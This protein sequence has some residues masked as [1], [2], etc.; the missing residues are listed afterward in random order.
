MIPGTAARLPDHTADNVN[1]RIRAA[2]DARVLDAARR[3]E[4]MNGRLDDI[5]RRLADLEQEW[6]IE[7]TL[8]TNAAALALTGT[9]LGAFVDRRFLALPALVTGFLLQHAIQGWCPPLPI[10]R[11]RGVRT[12]REITEE[13][14]ALKAL[15]GDFDNLPG[16]PATGGEARGRA[17]IVAARQR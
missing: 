17:A 16:D 8:E 2:S 9:V 12:Q 1:A 15:R 6:D 5:D 4:E 14:M 7:R 11:R 13:R 10:F 3:L